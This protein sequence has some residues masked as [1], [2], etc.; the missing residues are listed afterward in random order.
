MASAAALLL[1]LQ[2]LLLL[3]LSAAQPGE[4]PLLLFSR[5]SWLL[6]HGGLAHLLRLESI[7]LDAERVQIPKEVSAAYACS[8][9]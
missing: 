3:S 9:S 2:L 8:Y 1:Q 7:A 4:L 6:G 5:D